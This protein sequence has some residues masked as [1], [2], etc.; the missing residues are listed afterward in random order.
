MDHLDASSASTEPQFWLLVADQLA[1]QEFPDADR[2]VPLRAPVSGWPIRWF[3]CPQC[4]SAGPHTVAGWLGEEGRVVCH[5]CGTPWVPDYGRHADQTESRRELLKQAVATAYDRGSTFSGSGEANAQ[6]LH[7][8][9]RT[10]L[11]EPTAA[12]I[13]CARL[14]RTELR[15][16][17]RAGITGPE[18]VSL[19]MYLSSRRARWKPTRSPDFSR[20]L[21]GGVAVLADPEM[22]VDSMADR[23][24][25]A[26]M[27]L[28]EDLAECPLPP[29]AVPRWRRL[30]ALL[31]PWR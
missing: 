3:A 5:L 20:I 22:V 11:W 15:A 31:S 29:P 10:R 24:L 28:A 6:G 30:V 25:T 4:E 8:E 17:V 18:P 14:L 7:L 12:D 9:L 1:Y 23:I 13:E 2:R 21:A 26:L 16:A 19:S 27:E